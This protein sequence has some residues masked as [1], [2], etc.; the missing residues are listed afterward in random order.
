MKAKLRRAFRALTSMR[1]AI[2]LLILL[3]ALCALASVIPQGQNHDFYAGRYGERPADWLMALGLDDAFHS[4]LFVVLSA[5][6]CLELLLCDVIRFPRIVR[7]SRAF[8]DPLAYAALD[9]ANCRPNVRDA[10]TAFSRLG[11]AP[12]KQAQLPDGRTLLYRSRH[13]AGLWGAWLCHLGILVLIAGFTLGMFFSRSYSVYG[14]P[15]QQKPLA[16]TGCTV[17]IDDFAVERYASGAVRQ[18]ES[19]ITVHYGNKTESARVSVNGPA[20][21]FGYKFYQNSTGWAAQVDITKDG[22]PL[23][24]AVL[25]AGEALGFADKPELVLMLHNVY[26]DYVLLPGRGPAS[27]SD[28]PNNPAY[29]YALYYN[30]SMLG[31]NALLQGEEIDIDAYRVRIHTPQ[32]YTLLQVKRDATALWVLLG[33][34]ILLAGLALAFYMQPARAWAIQGEN[35][36]WSFYALCPKGGALFRQRFDVATKDLSEGEEKEDVSR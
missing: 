14:V 19:A 21:L 28:E 8:R 5:L 4:A 12:A 17:G 30:G 9:S 1:C 26:P 6:V 7:Q 13:A 24:S 10:E 33:A 29:L 22:Q 16:D 36:L 3:A 20:R 15:G 32:R 25:C 2:A 31:M 18:Y 34:L 27:A 23:Q 35:R 11:M